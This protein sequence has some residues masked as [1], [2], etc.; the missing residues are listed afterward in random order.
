MNNSS[1]IPLVIV[2]NSFSIKLTGETAEALLQQPRPVLWNNDGLYC[3]FP[4]IKIVNLVSVIKD[5]QKHAEANDLAYS[6]EI[7]IAWE[8]ALHGSAK[9]MVQAIELMSQQN[10]NNSSNKD[11][12]V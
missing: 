6:P 3:W 8:P 9:E 11:T 5:K 4:A 1:K 2:K 7:C 10:N 12:N